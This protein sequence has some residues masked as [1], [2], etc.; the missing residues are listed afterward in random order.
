MRRLGRLLPAGMA[1]ASARCDPPHALH[2][3]A[4]LASDTL[5]GVACAARDPAAGAVPAGDTPSRRVVRPGV[6]G[7]ARGRMVARAPHQRDGAG[8]DEP[9]LVEALAALYSY[10]YYGPDR[11]GC[12][13]DERPSP[14]ASA[15]ATMRWSAAPASGESTHLCFTGDVIRALTTGSSRE[16]AADPGDGGNRRSYAGS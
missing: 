14:R 7:R 11:D 5:G 4:P 8:P 9:P 2:V 6:R 15:K 16:P 10:V 3:R 12:F 1:P 13:H